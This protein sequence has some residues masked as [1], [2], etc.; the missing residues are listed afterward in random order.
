MRRFGHRAFYGDASRLDLLESAGAGSARVLIV[1]IDNSEKTLEI[2][3]LARR[4]FPHLRIVARARERRDQGVAREGIEH[5][6]LAPTPAPSL[7]ASL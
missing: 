2:V 3:E 6:R 5:A 4:H 1:A 7:S